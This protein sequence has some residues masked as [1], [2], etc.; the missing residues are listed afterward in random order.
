MK[1]FFQKLAMSASLMLAK[2]SG[3]QAIWA[4]E[5][6]QLMPPGHFVNLG[7]HRL[8]YEC[9]GT[10]RPAVLIDYGIGSS[11]I[12]WRALQRQISR[13]T[14]VCAYDRAGYG[15]SDP[16]P[17]PR[18]TQ[19]AAEEMYALLEQLAL[20]GPV[21]LVGH[22]FGGFNTR[23]FATRWPDRVAGLVWLDSSH[24]AEALGG[25]PLAPGARLHNPIDAT[26]LGAEGGDDDQAIGA[27]LNTRRK[28]IFTQ[29]DE[30]THF[31]ESARQVLNSGALPS[32][33]LLVLARDAAKGESG[34]AAEI[35]WHENQATLAALSPQGTLWQATGSG[36]DIHHDRPDLV[37][38]AIRKVLTSV[39]EHRKIPAAG[40]R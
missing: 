34:A 14:T 24:P 27:Y 39:R 20:D 23:Y 32:V 12:A 6:A 35:R 2:F 16:G 22:S 1:T 4:L 3:S 11:A 19:M 17:S 10:G 5:P 7:T 33:P 13:E 28:A 15:W 38:K 9:M 40:D 37:V 30:L 18:T 25:K 26:R 31:A 29:M 36:H 21:V 8:Y